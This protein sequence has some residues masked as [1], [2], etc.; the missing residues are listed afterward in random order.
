[1]SPWLCCKAFR[2]GQNLEDFK[3]RKTNIKWKQRDTTGRAGGPGCRSWTELEVTVP[4]AGVSEPCPPG[5]PQLPSC[6][7]SGRTAYL[8]VPHFCRL[9][10]I[11]AAKAD[12][13]TS[14][15]DNVTCCTGNVFMNGYTI[16]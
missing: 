15:M 10:D 13:V 7:A 1:M 14:S 3:V 9:E 16:L 11:R 4:E 2:S 12:N 6:A 5:S 8:S